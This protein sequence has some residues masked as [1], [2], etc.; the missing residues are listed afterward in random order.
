MAKPEYCLFDRNTQAII[1]GYQ[2]RAIQRMLDFD[3]ICRRETPSVAA[4]VAP[5]RQNGFHKCFFGNKEILIPIY[6]HFDEAV[7]KHQN[8]DVVVNFSSYRSAYATTMDALGKDTIRTVAIIAEGIPERYARIIAATA[9]EMKKCVIGPATVGGIAAGAF[10]IGNSAGTLENIIRCK[11]YRPGSVAFVSTS[12]GL[13][14]ELNNII[15]QATNGVYEG[16]AVGGDLYPG[17]TFIDHF[18]RYEANPDIKMMV[19]LGELGGKKE[20]E[21]IEAM[22]AGK[23]TKPVVAWCTGTCAKLFP[24]EVQFGHAGARAG[25][26][27]ETAEA[28]NRAFKEAGAIVPGSFDELRRVI[29]ETFEGLKARGVIPEIEEPEVPPVPEDYAEAKAKG[30]VRRATSFICTISNDSGEEATYND[31]P[32]SSVVEQGMGIGDVIGLLWLKCRLPKWAGEFIEMCLK[33]V[34]DH[35]PCV[36]GAHNAIVAS[37]AGKDL[38]SSLASGLL[39]IG[40]RFGGAIDGAAYY[41]RKFCDEGK[42]PRQMVNEMKAAGTLIQGIGHKIKSVRNPDKRVELLKNYAKE[43]FPATKYLDYALEVE[44]VTTA[45]RGN[46]ILNVD[47][48]IGVL[49]VDLLANL[50]FSSEEIG[51]IINAG[52]LY[53]VFVLGRSIGIIGHILDQKRLKAGLYRHPM[54]DILYA[55]ESPREVG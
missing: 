27:S 36:S 17:S 28:K 12:G 33:I 47:G 55:T 19:V 14:N 8:A 18:L 6:R 34:A 38:V 10:K 35:G 32:I 31:I 48:C 44:K 49:F 2:Q 1:Y 9:K 40:P 46:L 39:T 45:K 22:K 41:F 25:D 11:L 23:I 30:K 3:Y 4:I 29:R 26:D 7:E 42:T 15:S 50:G 13:F 52:T 5:T 16:I 21:V 51:E 20:Y 37:R 43:K 53:A 24:G 54:D